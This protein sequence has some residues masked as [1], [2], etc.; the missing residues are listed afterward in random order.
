MEVSSQ[1][2]D[3]TILRAP[4]TNWICGCVGPRSGLDEMAKKIESLPLPRI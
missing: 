1:L 3:P 2:H 4:D